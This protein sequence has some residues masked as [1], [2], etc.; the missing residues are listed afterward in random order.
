MSTSFSDTAGERAGNPAPPAAK[1]L[2]V[3]FQTLVRREFWEHRALWIAPAVVSALMMITGEDP[4]AVNRKRRDRWNGKLPT[5][6]MLCSNELQK[7]VKYVETGEADKQKQRLGDV[8]RTLLN[9]VE[10]RVN[11]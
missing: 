1:P 5:R 8:Y 3:T 7:L 11:H 9:S 10:F 2:A 6:I 4:I